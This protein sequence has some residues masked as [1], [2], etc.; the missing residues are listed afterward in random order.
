MNGMMPSSARNTVTFASY[1]R[2]HSD[3]TMAEWVTAE[4]ARGR[5]VVCRADKR[6]PRLDRGAV[7]AEWCEQTESDR[8]LEEVLTVGYVR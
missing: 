4:L 6:Y 3:P 7:L 1:R 8:R 2:L 5:A